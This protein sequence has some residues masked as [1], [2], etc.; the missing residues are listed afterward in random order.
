MAMVAGVVAVLWVL[1]LSV[2]TVRVV[3]TIAEAGPGVNV[4]ALKVLVD[5][6][7]VLCGKRK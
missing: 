2:A 6:I 3:R 1:I 5:L 7:K 4:K